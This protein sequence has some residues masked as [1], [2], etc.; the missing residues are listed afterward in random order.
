MTSFLL[1]YCIQN[2]YKKCSLLQKLKKR[3]GLY[4]L[5]KDVFRFYSLSTLPLFTLFC[6]EILV[7]TKFIKNLLGF[8]QWNVSKKAFI[9]RISNTSLKNHWKMQKNV[10]SI[11]DFGP[12]IYTFSANILENKRRKQLLNS[13]RV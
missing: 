13:V 6:D 11:D 9:T 8:L 5:T 4:V 7:Q 2:S 10:Y 3:G 12:I 1:L